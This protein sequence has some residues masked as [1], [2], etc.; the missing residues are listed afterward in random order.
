MQAGMPNKQN[1]FWAIVS[2][3]FASVQMVSAQ[4]NNNS[5]KVFGSLSHSEVYIREGAIERI[6]DYLKIWVLYNYHSARTSPNDERYQSA[7]TLFQ[8]DCQDKKSQKLN[9]YGHEEASGKGR[10]IDL[11]E[12]NPPWLELPPNSIGLHLIEAYC[13]PIVTKRDP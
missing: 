9:S 7:T 5:W 12:K 6:G 10:Q 4:S 13:L 8:F 3:F 11:L 1:Y 2:L